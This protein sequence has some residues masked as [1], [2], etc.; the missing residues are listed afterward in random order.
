MSLLYQ[1]V[2]MMLERERYIKSLLWPNNYEILM[3]RDSSKN[4]L[5]NIKDYMLTQPN[6]KRENWL[7]K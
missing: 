7:F 6:T 2:R 1:N 4:L 3:R 5:V